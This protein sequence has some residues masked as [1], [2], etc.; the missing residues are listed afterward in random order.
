MRVLVVDDD[1][2]SQRI[3]CNYLTKWGYEHT[4]AGDGEQGW[5]L[6]QQ[7]D[8]SIVVSDWLMPGL[9]GLG[10]M[11]RIRDWDAPN[12]QIYKILLTAKSDKEDLVEAMEAGADDFLTKPFDRDE[13]RVRLHEGEKMVEWDRRICRH[14]GEVQRRIDALRQV[15][16]QP[17]TDAAQAISRARHEMATLSAAAAELAVQLRLGSRTR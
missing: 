7:E 14:V 12:G 11:R 17:E 5:T 16:D 15:L 1:P 13:L 2:M 4:V 8:F 6:L 10:L 9:D 3:L